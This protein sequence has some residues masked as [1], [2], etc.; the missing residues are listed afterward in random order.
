MKTLQKTEQKINWEKVLE[1]TEEIFPKLRPNLESALSNLNLQKSYPLLGIDDY[2]PRISLSFY[3]REG[4]F[5]EE[6]EKELKEKQTEI[7]QIVADLAKRYD[8]EASAGVFFRDNHRGARRY[9]TKGLGDY[10]FKL[11]YKQFVGD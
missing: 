10:T 5:E 4:F 9:F 6:K 2:P 11:N 7:S 8:L 3:K 1:F